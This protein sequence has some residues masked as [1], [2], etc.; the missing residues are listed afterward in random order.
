MNV[1]RHRED[2]CPGALRPWP[3][4]D[5]L[6]VR[7][8]LI[9]GRV[10]SGSLRSLAEVSERFGDGH[11]HVTSRANLQVR[12]LPGAGDRLDDEVLAALDATRLLPSRSHEL[13][14]NVMVSP[15]TGLS[16]GRSDL[17]PVSAELDDLLCGTPPLAGLPARFL[18]VLDDGRGDLVGRACDLGLVALDER[19]G[20]LRLG[21]GWGDVLPLASAASR[22]GEL[23][24]RFLL[25]RGTGQSAAWHVVELT[26]PLG[27]LRA[28]DP[29]LPAPAAA[30][31]FGIGHGGEHVHVPETGLDVAAVTSLTARAD[32]L[33]VTPWRGILVPDEGS[34][35]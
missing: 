21:D 29:S 23:A 15:L 26:K 12:G 28:P 22:L 17:R 35:V 27:P 34:H 16:G 7:L 19:R 2:R 6:L 1:I 4:E 11:V 24:E 14:R 32:T 31:P 30:L 20:Q 3:A 25:A 9:G 33:I 5:G 13:V 18:F 8:R 10:S